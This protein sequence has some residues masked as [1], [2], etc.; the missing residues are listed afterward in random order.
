MRDYVSKLD[1]RLGAIAPEMRVADRRGM[2]APPGSVMT[3][4]PRGAS[5]A[6]R[7]RRAR[8]RTFGAVAIIGLAAGLLAAVLLR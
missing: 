1:D 7:T 6:P 2:R 3:A 4:T 8:A 5:P